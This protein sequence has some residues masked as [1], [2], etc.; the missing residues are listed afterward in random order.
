M[1]DIKATFLHRGKVGEQ[2][3]FQIFS[4]NCINIAF[5]EFFAFG[6]ATGKFHGH[7]FRK[8]RF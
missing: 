1:A 8:I 5:L 4:F 7:I 6:V 3:I 2:H